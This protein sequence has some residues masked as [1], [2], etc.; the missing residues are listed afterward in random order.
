MRGLSA[1][2]K[3]YDA[4]L[5]KTSVHQIADFDGDL[6]LEI[7]LRDCIG[8]N[9]WH[10]PEHYEWMER[11]LFC[12]AIQSGATVLDVGANI[13][14]F[15]LLAAKRKAHV[16]SIEADAKNA[17]ALRR[18]IS[19]N[20]FNSRVKVFE[21]AAGDSEANLSLYRNETNSGGSTLVGAGAG[22]PVQ[23]RPIDSLDLPPIDVC[24]IDV[25]G[26]E[27]RVLKGMTSTLARSRNMKLLIEYSEP[28]GREAAQEMLKFLRRRFERIEVVGGGLLRPDSMPPRYC[29]L[30]CTG[31][32]SG[33][34]VD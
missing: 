1:L 2:L 4:V 24:K 22:I 12:S 5:P 19:L 31:R 3:V 15:T 7:S 27:S 28:H 32:A 30:W 11:R 34:D 16:F 21:M 13:G 26:F 29:N 9:L 10:A 18:H 17:S 25:E 14:V 33:G 6:S 8:V 23:S 20:R